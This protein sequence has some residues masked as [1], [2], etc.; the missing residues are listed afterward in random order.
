[1]ILKELPGEN[2]VA[3]VV[4]P[5]KLGVFWDVVLMWHKGRGGKKSN[6]LSIIGERLIILGWM[7]GECE[8]F[9]CA[10]LELIGICGGFFALLNS[11]GFKI[12]P[13]P[14]EDP[15]D[16]GIYAPA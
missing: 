9:R 7:R 15:D 14:R 8:C 10:G 13:A 4:A 3:G 6:G 1:M 12:V 16:A 5:F 2:V 11:L